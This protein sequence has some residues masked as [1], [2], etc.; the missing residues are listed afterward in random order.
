MQ[1]H[2][3]KTEED[4]KFISS[5]YNPKNTEFLTF[6]KMSVVAIFANL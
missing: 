3:T 1:Y 5:L 2:L 4:F 6:K